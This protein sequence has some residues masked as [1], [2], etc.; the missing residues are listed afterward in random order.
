M[1]TMPSTAVIRARESDWRVGPVVYQ[2]FLDRFAPPANLESKRKYINPPRTLMPWSAVPKAGKQL[3]NYGLWS[4]ELEFWGGDFASLE[5]KL[6]YIKNL[7]ADVLYLQPIQQSFTNHK[8]DTQ[9]YLAIDPAY[10][11]DQDLVNLAGNL[12][13]AKMK[14]ML[15]GVFNHVGKTSP[16][17]ES[18]EKGPDSR[19]RNWFD[20]GKQYPSGYRCYFGVANMPAL[21]L[22]NSDVRDYLWNSPNSVVRKYL[23]EGAD[24]WRLDVAYQLGP[25]YLSELTHVAH[26]EKPGSAVVG[27]ISGY[28]ADWFPSVDGVFDFSQIEVAKSMLTGQISG[29][30]AGHIVDHMVEDAGIENLLRSWL[31]TDNHDTPRLASAIPELKNR[32]FLRALQFSLPGAPVLYY[33][34]E[35]GMTGSG[36]PENRAPMRWDLATDK[37]PELAFVEKLIRIRKNHPCLRLGDFHALDSERLFAFV[38]T[39]DKVLDSMLVAANPTG[40]PVTETLAVRMG[41]IMS[42]GE[43]DDILSGEKIKVINGLAT[44]TV[45]PQSVM[46]FTPDKQ[47]SGGYSQY[48]RIR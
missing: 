47:I 2:V 37:N 36:D 23:R 25:D 12:H 9:D 45:P 28:P 8:Y 13:Q 39:T 42:Y 32:N 40:Q 5:G 44:V 19:Y 10:G 6:S 29:G 11:T 18:A 4:H 33:G 24:G 21:N 15:D 31:L 35:L 20:W 30:Q 26:L 38:R 48:H 3:K 1:S 27:E 16:M 7:G 43:M 17:F 46:L 34:S 14:L 41:R 22:E